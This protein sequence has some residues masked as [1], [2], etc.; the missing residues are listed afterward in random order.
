MVP[1]QSP[2]C[3]EHRSTEI[4]VMSINQPVQGQGWSWRYSFLNMTSEPRTLV[5]L[6]LSR[7]LE[8]FKVGVRIRGFSKSDWLLD[9][10]GQGWTKMDQQGGLCRS[11]VRKGSTTY[12]LW[13]IAGAEIRN[14]GLMKN[15]NP[16]ST[17]YRLALKFRFFSCLFLIMFLSLLLLPWPK[18]YLSE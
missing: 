5:L 2:L 18:T 8:N 16:H 17:V 6:F 10:T 9:V 4:D 14:T 12:H 7:S 3:R 1:S 15:K 11:P 13:Q